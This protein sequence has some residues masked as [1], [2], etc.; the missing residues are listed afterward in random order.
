MLS[1]QGKQRT[2]QQKRSRKY[3]AQIKTYHYRIL[4][5]SFL[6]GIIKPGIPISYIHP[7]L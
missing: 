2:Q 6:P 5:G 1:G 4:P 7:F 3:H